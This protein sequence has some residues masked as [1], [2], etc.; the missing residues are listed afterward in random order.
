MKVEIEGDLIRYNGKIVARISPML[1][2]GETRDFEDFIHGIKSATV[3]ETVRAVRETA[4]RELEEKA[5]ASGG[6]FT[7]N[8]VKELIIL[9]LRA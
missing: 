9:E 7:V 5:E 1:T 2:L 3:Q 4:M 6:L 8:E